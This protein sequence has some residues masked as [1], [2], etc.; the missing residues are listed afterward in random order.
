LNTPSIARIDV[1]PVWIG[2]IPVHPVRLRDTLEFIDRVASAESDDRAI[3]HYAN[4]H[5]VNLAGRNA[6]FR[7]AMVEASLVFCDGKSLQWAARMLGGQLPERFTPPDW[8]D[9]LAELCVDRSHRLFFLGALEGVAE[10]GAE[11][12]RDRHPGLEV[13]T[14]HGYFDRDGPAVDHLVA[15]VNAAGPDILLVGLGMPDQERWVGAHAARLEAS[16]IVTVGG[17]FDFISGHKRRGPRWL[18]SA[19]LEWLTRLVTE[20]RRLSSRYLLG[21][22][23]FVWTVMRQRIKTGTRN[24]HMRG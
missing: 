12:L 10:A 21:N 1:E 22:P 15:E 7:D 24:H 6:S 4:A 16:V 5:A 8:I 19:G 23:R 3:I 18:T 17:L 13:E 9:E 11:V 20:P 2:S 14:R